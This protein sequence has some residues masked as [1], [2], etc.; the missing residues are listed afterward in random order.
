MLLAGVARS[1]SD[2]KPPAAK[3]CNVR[4]RHSAASIAKQAQ[5]RVLLCQ[6]ADCSELPCSQLLSHPP[7]LLNCWYMIAKEWMRNVLWQVCALGLP[8]LWQQCHSRVLHCRALALL[9]TPIGT[10]LLCG[11]QCCT[12]GWP[13]I[14]K[15]EDL[16]PNNVEAVVAG[17]HK[18]RFKL[19]SQLARLLRALVMSTLVNEASAGVLTSGCTQAQPKSALHCVVHAALSHVHHCDAHPCCI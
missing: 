3:A 14:R 15:F 4:R 11:L 16:P 8:L 19:K 10:L 6:A 7:S 18:S 9:S 2:A 1:H 5:W 12:F 17:W 13:F